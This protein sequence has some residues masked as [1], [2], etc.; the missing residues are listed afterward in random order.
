MRREGKQFCGVDREAEEHTA[1]NEIAEANSFS[2][3]E[4]GGEEVAA[5]RGRPG[6]EV[7]WW[8]GDEREAGGDG[9]YIVGATAWWWRRRW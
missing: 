6:G 9:D 8:I 7:V 3:L 4:G 2:C 1:S 5:L